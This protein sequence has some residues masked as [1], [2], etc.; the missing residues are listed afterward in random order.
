MTSSLVS[1]LIGPEILE[2]RILLYSA[3][4]FLQH[5]VESG[6]VVVAL[7]TSV[8]LNKTTRLETKGMLPSLCPNEDGNV[9]NVFL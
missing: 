9:K 8:K 4:D 7:E 6:H 3:L 5:R 1:T 2:A